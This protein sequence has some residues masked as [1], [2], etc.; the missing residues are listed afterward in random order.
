MVG[1]TWQYMVNHAGREGPGSGDGDPLERARPA[2]R[3]LD[4]LVLGQEPVNCMYLW[5]NHIITPEVNATDGVLR[6]GPVNAEAC[7]L[8][9]DKNHCKTFHAEDEEYFSK[10][11]YWKTPV[12]DCGDD[13]GEVCKDSRQWTAAWTRSRASRTR[14]TSVPYGEAPP[15]EGPGR[16][17][18]A[19]LF[20][21][22]R[23][24]LGALLPRPRVA[25]NRLPRLARGLFLTAVWSVDPFTGD[26]VREFTF[27]NFRTLWEEDVYRRITTWTVGLAAA[28]TVTDA[29]LALPIA[30]YM[31]RIASPRTKAILVVAI[32]RRLGELPREGLR[33]A[34]H[35]RRAR[36]S[37]LGTRAVRPDRARLHD[38]RNLAHVFTYL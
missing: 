15:R 8:T 25:G 21:H 36:P 18:S 26:I 4:D 22:P 12:K 33:V 29:L 38:D 11:A 14:L 27:D 28:V 13:R 32:L 17:L 24:R 5:M 37:E 34:D 9:T 7:N 20:R 1:T 35:P 6:G 16:R 2:G 31:A 30:Y 10:V 19:F 3:N 23:A